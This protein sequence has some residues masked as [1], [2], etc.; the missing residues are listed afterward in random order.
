MEA[1]GSL[2]CSQG[3]HRSAQSILLF[4][5]LNIH[6]NIILLFNALQC[7]C[8]DTYNTIQREPFFSG[9][10]KIEETARGMLDGT[11]WGMGTG[12]CG[13]GH[14]TGSTYGQPVPSKVLRYLPSKIMQLNQSAIKFIRNERLYV[15]CARKCQKEKIY[16]ITGLLIHMS[17]ISLWIQDPHK[18]NAIRQTV[19]IKA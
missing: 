17:Y 14:R 15:K 4:Y 11:G 6:F 18:A 9:S 3:S 19:L 10:K 2:Q 13:T 12:T 1:E 7:R 5:F 8:L 16:L